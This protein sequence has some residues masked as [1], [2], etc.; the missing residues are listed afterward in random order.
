[1]SNV[2]KEKTYENVVKLIEGMLF[3]DAEIEEFWDNGWHEQSRGMVLQNEDVLFVLS[4]I[5]AHFEGEL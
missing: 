5:K 4:T 1:M 3:T 2:S